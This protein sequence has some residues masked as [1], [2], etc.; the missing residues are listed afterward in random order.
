MMDI[1]YYTSLP[2]ATTVDKC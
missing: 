2:Y 1:E